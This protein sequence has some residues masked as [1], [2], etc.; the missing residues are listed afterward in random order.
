MTEMPSDTQPSSVIDSNSNK[1]RN[2]S[3]S[4]DKSTDSVTTKR[5]RSTSALRNINAGA[6]D[7]ITA[8]EKS[9]EKSEARVLTQI[10]A[11]L[12]RKISEVRSDFDAKLQ[13]LSTSVDDRIEAAVLNVN[14]TAFGDKLDLAVSTIDAIAMIT[15][16][17]IESLERSRC[18]TDVIINGIPFVDKEDVYDLFQ[19]ICKE[20]GVNFGF[21]AVS[22]VFRVPS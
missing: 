6:L 17:R 22:S 15:D 12:D 14:S 9:I 1:R 4:H 10:E 13:A 5:T 19:R 8:I 18:L 16:T 11:M 7:I 21:Q 3:G 20:I 2:R